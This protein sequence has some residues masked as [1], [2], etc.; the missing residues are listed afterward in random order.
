MSSAK[1]RWQILAAALRPS[2]SS[3]SSSSSS[4]SPSATNDLLAEGA[5]EGADGVSVRR[6][7]SYNLFEVTPA[8]TAAGSSGSTAN[9]SRASVQYKIKAA[10]GDSDALIIS[11]PSSF[12]KA[13]T[14][15]ALI[16]FNNT[17]NVCVWPSEEVLAGKRVIEL[18][19]GYSALAALVVAAT[20]LPS[21]VVMNI[22][23][24]AKAL[25]CPVKATMLRWDRD[26]VKASG[27]QG[28]FDVVICADCLFF[29]EFHEG[30]CQTLQDLVGQDGTILSFAPTRGHTLDAF[31]RVAS[32][33]FE[34]ERSDDYEPRVVAVR[35]A[36]EAKQQSAL[37]DAAGSPQPFDRNLHYPVFLTL[38][39]LKHKD[40]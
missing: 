24:N 2:S 22:E 18:G 33:S 26:A 14:P 30:L 27:L 34:I 3:S 38:R 13:V 16:G 19:S 1:K 37:T 4:P 29:E 6:F 36:Q 40:S 25:N 5:G 23:A 10:S 8:S 35:D 32:A 7:A 28:P 12:K 15:E 20:G 21:E 11:H 31:C 17:G 9:T 39:R